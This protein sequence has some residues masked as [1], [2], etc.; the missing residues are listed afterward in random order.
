MLRDALR[1]AALVTVL[2]GLSAGCQPPGGP[3]AMAGATWPTGPGTPATLLNPAAPFQPTS[4][5]IVSGGATPTGS[6][7]A[8]ASPPLQP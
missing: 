2:A 5:V 1:V 3:G 7:G 8:L 6:G 4:G